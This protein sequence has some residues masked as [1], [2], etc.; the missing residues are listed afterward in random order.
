MC[1]GVGEKERFSVKAFKNNRY[2]ND[3]RIEVA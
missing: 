3:D 1:K 2:V